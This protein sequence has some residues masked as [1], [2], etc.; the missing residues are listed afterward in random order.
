MALPFKL[1]AGGQFGDGTQYFPTI[2]LHDYVAAVDRLASDD[3]MSG[4]YNVVAPVPATNRE[5]TTS[6]GEQ[7][8]RPTKIR[9]PAFAIKA[10]TGELSSEFLGSVHAVPLRL[11]DA[12]FTFEY[13][14]VRDQLNAALS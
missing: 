9:V 14:T 6:L 5:F 2:A 7:L 3:S 4:A 13:P 12:G 10:A 8:H 1:G 11:T